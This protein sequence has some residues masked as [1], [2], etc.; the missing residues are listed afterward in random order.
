M[1][2]HQK[3]EIILEQLGVL[4]Y[5]WRQKIL[6]DAL[7]AEYDEGFQNGMSSARDEQEY[8]ARHDKSTGPV[9]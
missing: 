3:A 9:A 5:K 2:S 6:V 7:E 1:N 4:H 8:A